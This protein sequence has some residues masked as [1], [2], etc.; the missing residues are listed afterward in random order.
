MKGF[1]LSTPLSV[2]I[3]GAMLAL[4]AASLAGGNATTANTVKTASRNLTP[5]PHGTKVGFIPPGLMKGTVTTETVD[6]AEVGET[7]VFTDCLLDPGPSGRVVW[8][9]VQ[10]VNS[11]LKPVWAGKGSWLPA[12]D[13]LRRSIKG[14]AVIVE[15]IVDRGE[16]EG[17]PFTQLWLKTTWAE[18]DIEYQVHG[19]NVSEEDLLA[20]AGSITQ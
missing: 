3:C 20:F 9:R 6:G 13:K 15:R 11:G 14:R 10:K 19:I 8:L 2:L 7:V 5:P 4:G 16:F 17:K 18:G 1:R 12:A